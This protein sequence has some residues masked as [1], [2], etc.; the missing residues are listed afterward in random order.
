MELDHMKP[1][2]VHIID[3]LPPDGAERLLVDVLQ[4]RSNKYRY[5]V[6]CI[7]TGGILV[8]EIERL[9]IPV[10]IMARH[11]KYDIKYLLR[12]ASWLRNKK[13]IAVHTHL[14]TADSW[15]R[16][17]ALIASVPGIFSTVHSTNTW[18]SWHHRFVDKLLSYIS[19]KIIACSEQVSDVLIND[20]K[21]SSELVITIPNGVNLSRFDSLPVCNYYNETEI[22]RTTAR[23]ILV[24]RLHEAKGHLDVL[25]VI[26]DLAQKKRNFHLS[27][28]GEGELENDISAFITN[29]NLSNYVSLLGFRPDVLSLIHASDVVIMPSRWEG[30]PMAL[31]ESMAL[32]KP[33]IAFA[34]GGIPNVI[35]DKFNGILITPGDFADFEKKLDELI[36]DPILREKLG[37]QANATVYEHYSAASVANKYESLYDEVNVSS[38]RNLLPR[39]AVV[40]KNKDRR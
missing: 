39:E 12:L 6:L 17:A 34:V 21:I 29:N 28:V 32:S 23:L 18:M 2:V 9:G 10:T 31:L 8:D 35:S 14:F 27:F 30:L 40:S 11:N 7:I 3:R 26:H 25:P 22:D 4:N 24:G 33:V 19:T 13:P 38:P 16:L 15:G 36:L 37:K 5:H 1:L 20:G